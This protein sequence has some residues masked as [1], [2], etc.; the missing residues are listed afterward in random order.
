MIHD[1][2]EFVLEM[3]TYLHAVRRKVEKG[4]AEELVQ[5]IIKFMTS[6][7]KATFI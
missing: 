3:L 7:D 4:K 1:G 6:Y 2:S 5:Q